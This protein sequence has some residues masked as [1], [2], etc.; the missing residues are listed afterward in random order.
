MGWENS[1]MHQYIDKATFYGTVH[2]DD[3]LEMENERNYRIGDLLGKPKDRIIYEY[4]FGD[5]WT[6][7]IVLEEILEKKPRG[8]YPLVIAGKKACPPEDCGGIGGYY[9]FLDAINDPQHADHEEMMEWYGED[10]DPDA[11]NPHDINVQ[12]HVGWVAK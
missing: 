9:H 10:F 2:N 7:D 5:G 6:H 3:M 8:K 11:F 1:H 12:Y 4:D